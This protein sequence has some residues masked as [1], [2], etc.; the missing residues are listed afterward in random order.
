M[1]IHTPENRHVLFQVQIVSKTLLNT[2]IDVVLLEE[3]NCC[4]HSLA[5]AHVTLSSQS[6]ASLAGAVTLFPQLRT[7]YL[8]NRH[9]LVQAAGAR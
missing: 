8:S 9:T 2:R 5:L 7:R 6:Y 3:A 4:T 1:L